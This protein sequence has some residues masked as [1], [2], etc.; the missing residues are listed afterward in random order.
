MAIYHSVS[1][2]YCL[3][4]LDNSPLAKAYACKRY[5]K[6]EI[7]VEAWQMHRGV[8]PPQWF[9]R[10]V[11]NGQIYKRVDGGVISGLFLKTAEGFMPLEF[12]DYIVRENNGKLSVVRSDMFKKLYVP[13]NRR[14]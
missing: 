5:V 13:V 14:E 12:G 9:L 11:Q 3:R 2:D 6:K 10:A 4:E 8:S 7:P 1:P